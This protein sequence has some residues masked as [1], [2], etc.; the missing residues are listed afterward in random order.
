MQIRELRFLVIGYREYGKT[1]G[2]MKGLP[3]IFMKIKE[4]EI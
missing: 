1:H 2:K 3:D 4:I